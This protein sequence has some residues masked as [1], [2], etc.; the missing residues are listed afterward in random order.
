MKMSRKCICQGKKKV[1][2]EEKKNK[3]KGPNGGF[4]KAFLDQTCMFCI[5]QMMK[6]V[7]EEEHAGSQR[8][9]HN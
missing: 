4:W 1:I 2:S 6:A 8:S 9:H 5:K 7:S 3:E